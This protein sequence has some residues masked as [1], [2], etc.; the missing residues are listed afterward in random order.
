ML[1]LFDREIAHLAFDDARIAAIPAW[2][3]EFAGDFGEEYGVMVIMIRE[4]GNVPVSR[5][6]TG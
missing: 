1:G 5:F 3:V 6:W 2:R 4:G